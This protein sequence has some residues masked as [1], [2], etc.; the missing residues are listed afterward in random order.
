MRP[1]L[2]TLAR[3]HIVCSNAF[4][5]AAGEQRSTILKKNCV[6]ETHNTRNCPEFLPYSN[7]CPGQLHH[8]YTSLSPAS[9]LEASFRINEPALSVSVTLYMLRRGSFTSPFQLATARNS[10]VGQNAMREIESSGGSTTSISFGWGCCV[11]SVDRA[12]DMLPVGSD[13]GCA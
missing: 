3:R 10:A 9:H 11:T 13:G 2:A 5:C 1:N 12:Y 6:Y 4:V 7:K 8:V